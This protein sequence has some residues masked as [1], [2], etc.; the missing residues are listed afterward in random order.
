MLLRTG[1]RRMRQHSLIREAE[2]AINGVR[3]RAHLKPLQQ[4]NILRVISEFEVAFFHRDGY[5]RIGQHLNGIAL[6]QIALAYLGVRRLS[7]ELPSGR[8][9][10]NEWVAKGLGDLMRQGGYVL[11]SGPKKPW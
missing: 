5:G 8:R 11:K 10:F 1:Y 6:F 3:L 2:C 9:V 7:G 4:G